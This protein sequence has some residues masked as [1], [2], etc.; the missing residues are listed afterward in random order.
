M[1]LI[2]EFFSDD[3]EPETS[4]VQSSDFATLDSKSGVGAVVRGRVKDEKKPPSF[5]QLWTVEEQ[6]QLEDLLIKFPP[7][8]VEAR[9]WEKIAKALGNRTT[10]QVLNLDLV[11]I[12]FPAY[13]KILF[14]LSHRCSFIAFSCSTKVLCKSH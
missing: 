1:S 7:E 2:L 8:E 5:N 6:K 4:G 3:Q 11:L 13:C 10:Q 14:T 12:L 9:R